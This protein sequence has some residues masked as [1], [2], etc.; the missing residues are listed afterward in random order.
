MTVTTTVPATAS[1]STAPSSRSRRPARWESGRWASARCAPIAH[2][3]LATGRR[4]AGVAVRA[5]RRPMPYGAFPLG[6]WGP[7][8]SPTSPKMPDRRG[9]PGA[10]PGRSSRRGRPSPAA[11]RPSTTTASTRRGPGGRCRSCA[12]A[13]PTR[14]D[15]SRPAATLGTLVA[16]AAHERR[17][18]RA[19]RRT[20][21]AGPAPRRSS[22][23]PG[24]ASAGRWR[25][26]SARS[27]TGW[28]RPTTPS[29]PSSAIPSRRR[30]GRRH[31]PRTGGA[32]VA[33][34]GHA[35]RGGAQRRAATTVSDRPRRGPGRAADGGRVA[36]RAGRGPT[37]R[38]RRVAEPRN[39]TV[40]PTD[41]RRPSPGPRARWLRRR[42]AARW[43]RSRPA[44]R[45]HRR[46]WAATDASAA[47]AAGA[48]A[49]TRCRRAAGEVVAVL[50]LPNAARDVTAT[51]P[52]RS[53]S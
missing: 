20:G 43:R 22:W 8:Q 23:R 10:E 14:T 41:V 13:A 26:C 53:S 47:V 52:A 34:R 51:T 18:R 15:R 5:G 21:G 11:G 4:R 37:R 9:R 28:P 19:R 35:A 7:P 2:A 25:R 30:P 16:D 36:Q 32:G 27:A 48:G 1:T 46:R 3:A 40:V 42:R 33:R 49:A 39:G 38:R 6:V 50:A 29:C 44:R 12:T 24:R 17:R 45:D 31:G